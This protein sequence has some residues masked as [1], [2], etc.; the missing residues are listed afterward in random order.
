MDVAGIVSELVAGGVG[1]NIAGAALKKFDLGPI[2]N[3][4][5]G[6][7]GG[8]AGGQILSMLI[9]AATAAPAAGAGGMAGI[10]SSVAGGGVGGAIL[11]AIVG[12]VKA[13][14][15]KSA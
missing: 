12:L 7:L 13:Q 5:A 9:P 1:G 2:G 3:T 14:M 4:V 15:A 11:M 8:A 6:V 10:I